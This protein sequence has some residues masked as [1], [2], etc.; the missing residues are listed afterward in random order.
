[1]C[2]D[3][4]MR[5]RESFIGLPRRQTPFKNKTADF[6]SCYSRTL[7]DILGGARG[8]PGARIW[9]VWDF[10]I[11]LKRFDLIFWKKKF[12]FCDFGENRQIGYFG[13]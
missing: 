13:I 8:C 7:L 3:L 2:Y 12:F 1:M 4:Q 10:V 11:S 9:H 6:D 5:P